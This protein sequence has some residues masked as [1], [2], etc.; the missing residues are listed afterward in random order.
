MEEDLSNDL[1]CV[2]WNLKSKLNQLINQCIS[3]IGEHFIPICAPQ[4][5]CVEHG[6]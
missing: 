2:E 4:R 1:F 5:V 6:H 3:N